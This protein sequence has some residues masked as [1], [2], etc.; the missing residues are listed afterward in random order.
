LVA[1]GFVLTA[2][3]GGGEIGSVAGEQ[4]SAQ[5]SGEAPDAQIQSAGV[6]AQSVAPTT[7]TIAAFDAAPD[8][9]S[10]WRFVGGP[11]F[12]G[13]SGALS[14][15]AGV[16]GGNA[17]RLDYDLGCSTP[18]VALHSGETCGKYV[19][20]TTA[21]AISVPVDSGSASFLAFDTRNPQ[22]VVSPMV[23]VEDATGQTLQF[24]ATSR[25]LESVTGEAWQRVHLP[26]S[27][28]SQHWG[29][30]NDG[31]LHS[32][33]RRISLGAADFPQRQP[34][35]WVEFDNVSVVQNP[36]YDYT[37]NPTAPVAAGSFYPSYVGRLAVNTYTTNPA[38]L[39]KAKATGITV[40]RMDL[41]WGSIEKNGT[42]DF[43]QYNTIAD[44][45]KAKGMSVLWIL[46]YGHSD[47]GGGAPITD[48][49]RT[50]FANF[51]RAA[52]QN[53]KGKN[54]VGFEIWN[55]PNVSYFWP[56]PDPVA[57]AKLFNAAASA[58]RGA[59]PTVKIVSGGTAGIDV[60]YSLVM[61]ENLDPS[62]ID[63]F[64]VHPYNKPAPELFAA[65]YA[66]LK[67]VLVSR[68]ITKP[69]WS[70]EWGYS[71]YG[72][73]D[74]AKYGNGASTSARDR[75]AV[76]V[77]RRVLTDLAMNTPF[78]NIYG[79][80]DYGTDPVNRENNFGLLTKDASDKPAILALRSLYSAQSGRSFKGYLPAVPPGL[81]ALR[82][83]SSTDSVFA[84]WSDNPGQTVNV[85]LPAGTLSARWWNGIPAA[86]F[87]TAG[88]TA[89]SLGEANGP[90]FVR[91]PR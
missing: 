45:L 78:L 37:I 38:A 55:E 65:G 69:I 57:Y 46:D 49:A 79:L 29:G 20:M 39:D 58:I 30:A 74:S 63:A 76:L 91:V 50:G 11:E 40:V 83:D 18:T 2:C 9:I 15:T 35:G 89:L 68:G 19:Q 52:A 4:S 24:Y 17:A 13:A 85:T 62:L 14:Q 44:A 8:A 64:G 3:G 23:R 36:T 53:F 6:Q 66:P 51:A 48:A 87:N 77:L 21:S 59:D 7:T 28:S 72:D 75:Q 10:N 1:L 80:T 43:S 42:Y 70:T 56:N 61:A 82:W 86:T 73:F 33:I 32:P 34:A 12:P 71:S 47:Y 81:H 84:I 26:I 22:G 90:L 88:G 16:G 54:V 25:T 5:Q 41:S 31:V 60:N 67:N 27:S